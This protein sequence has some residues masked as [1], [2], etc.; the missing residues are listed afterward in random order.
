MNQNKLNYCILVTLLSTCLAHMQAEEDQVIELNDFVVVGQYLQSDQ[1]NALKTP[2]PIEDIP[3]SLNI[4]T[5]DLISLQDLSSMSEI[6]DY[7][8]GIDAGQGE[9]HRDHILFRGV[10]T[11]ADFFIDGVRDDVQY[12]R[13]LYNIEQVEILKGANA[14]FFGRGGIGGLINR[15]SKTAQ[16][17]EGFS[18]YQLSFNDNGGNSLQIDTNR[19]IAP[20]AALRFNYYTE[21]LENHRD[22][23]FGDN[24]GINPTLIYVLGD[25]TTLN[26]SDESLDHER[27]IDRGIPTVGGSPVESLAGITFGSKEDNRS[28][29]DA[30]TTNLSIDHQLDYHSK[31]RFNYTDNDFAK[32]YQNLYASDYNSSTNTVDLTGYRDT[33]DRSSEIFSIDFIGKKEIKGLS[34]KFVLG[35]EKIKTNNNNERF[36]MDTDGSPSANR[37][38]EKLTNIAVNDPLDISSYSYNFTTEHYDQTKAA[39]DVTS[40]YFSDEIAL[41]KQLDFVLGGRFDSYEISVDDIINRS[42]GDASKKDEAFSPRLGIVY[43]PNNNITYYASYSESFL[44]AEGDQY[45]DLNSSKNYDTLGPDIYE[46]IEIGGKFNLDNGLSLTTALYDLSA[47]LPEG[48][49]TIPGDYTVKTKETKGIEISATGNLSDDWFISAG[50]NIILGDAPSEVADNSFS[51]WNLYT[52]DSKLRLGLGIVHKG[53]TIGNGDKNNLPSYTRI[54]AAAYYKINKNLRLQLNIENVTDELYFPNSYSTHQVTVGAPLNATLKIVG[55]F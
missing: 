12:Y 48:D 52:V 18:E 32:M 2:T 36:Y 25:K 29:L 6:A 55:R 38:G 5:S 43:K 37:K 34:H 1:I 33:T 21:D 11:T 35:L 49:A 17:G 8:P 13:P 19:A 45:A 44:P 16:I 30:N 53:D 23:F 41:S 7:V 4:L 26:L 3:Q 50:A 54:D 10:K 22:F 40:L 9:G 42:G 14:L 46:N 47:K 51:L 28:T 20:N 39:L 15:V 24:S 31:I 27:Y